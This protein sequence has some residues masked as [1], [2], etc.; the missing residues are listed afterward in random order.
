MN[1]L[2]ELDR[3]SDFHYYNS[4]NNELL[5]RISQPTREEA[6]EEHRAQEEEQ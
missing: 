1:I 2:E 4:D 6:Q 3:M 5:W